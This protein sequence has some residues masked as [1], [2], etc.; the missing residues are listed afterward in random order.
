MLKINGK[1]VL[2]TATVIMEPGDE[3]TLVS[4]HVP[5]V[6]FNLQAI[7]TSAPIGKD[8]INVVAENNVVNMSFPFLEI[9]HNMSFGLPDLGSS[10]DGKL[11]V[12]IAGTAMGAVMAVYLQFFLE[13]KPQYGQR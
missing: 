12:Q 13:R 6:M 8:K 9:G 3:V 1:E 5:G 11:S 10:A 2:D 7:K 4:S